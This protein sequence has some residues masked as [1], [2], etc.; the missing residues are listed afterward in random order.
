MGEKEHKGELPS[1]SDLSNFVCSLQ[2]MKMMN[3]VASLIGDFQDVIEY[4]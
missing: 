2:M 1:W 4:C 3:G